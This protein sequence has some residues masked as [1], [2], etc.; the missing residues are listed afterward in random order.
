MVDLG[1]AEID[2]FFKARDNGRSRVLRPRW[3]IKDYVQ[4]VIDNHID[5]IELVGGWRWHSKPF[6]EMPLS[7]AA[8][9][10]LVKAESDRWQNGAVLYENDRKR[11]PER[12]APL[13]LSDM[14]TD[15]DLVY[16][17]MHGCH[18]PKPN[19]AAYQLWRASLYS[20]SD[21][22]KEAVEEFA[23]RCKL[24][25]R[26]GQAPTRAVLAEVRKV[27]KEHPQY[28]KMWETICE[29]LGVAWTA[30][31]G[32]PI[33]LTVAPVDFL[34]LGH[35][36]EGNSCYA[37]GGASE[38]AKHN[39][40][41]IPNSV[42]SLFYTTETVDA[43]PML[44][45]PNQNIAGRCWGVL[46][47]EN[48]GAAFSNI[49]R[50]T[51]PEVQPSLEAALKQLFGWDVQGNRPIGNAFVPFGRYAYTNND[52]NLYANEK[53]AAAVQAGIAKQLELPE[54]LRHEK[55]L[56]GGCATPFGHRSMLHNC[57][58]GQHSCEN[59]SQTTECCK[60]KHCKRCK[61]MTYKCAGCGKQSCDRCRGSNG[62]QAICADT[63]AQ[64]CGECA[65]KRM[66]K[67]IHCNK[68][69]STPSICHKKP[70]DVACQTCAKE[71]HRTCDR[72]KHTVAL[73]Y[74]T[75]CGGCKQRRCDDC[76]Q[77]GESAEPKALCR[78]C[79]QN[80]VPAPKA[81]EP[82]PALLEQ[83]RKSLEALPPEMRDKYLARMKEFTWDIDAIL[84]DEKHADE[85]E[86]EAEEE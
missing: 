59:C 2:A 31:K 77:E 81:F 65:D 51:F 17:G 49:Y 27:F 9:S 43:N 1:M 28:V 69:T 86:E 64:F 78:T 25:V 58:C 70:T 57:A 40:S 79:T 23:K 76:L 8:V 61:P 45:R 30:S 7:P 29:K 44:L 53:N 10:A 55:I 32:R 21:G 62:M 50:L 37:T 36:E 71:R 41:L 66:K 42:V 12:Q 83:F 84:L 73:E 18:F 52:T 22:Q 3:G 6:A 48:G 67:C 47:M 74:I 26:T 11:T 39:L 38:F 72:C 4:K 13:P 19:E 56:C 75:R 16:C 24:K 20:A 82:D 63:G 60:A 46:D 85:E 34:K 14:L 15:A 33:T 35:Y 54:A 68:A 80:G 5:F